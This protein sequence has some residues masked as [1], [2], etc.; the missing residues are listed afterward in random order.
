MAKD[1]KK[2]APPAN[3]S[4]FGFSYFTYRKTRSR[5]RNMQN[6]TFLSLIINGL[7]RITK[8]K[9]NSDK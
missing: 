1:L 6:L 8:I 9:Q 2:P 5:S 3:A 4:L 7:F